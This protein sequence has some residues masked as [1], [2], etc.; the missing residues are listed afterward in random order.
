MGAIY[1]SYNPKN[2]ELSEK[3]KNNCRI[4]EVYNYQIFVEKNIRKY[5]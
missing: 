3:Y 1:Y 4:I 2:I 5:T